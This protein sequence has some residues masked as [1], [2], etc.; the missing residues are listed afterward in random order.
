MVSQLKTRIRSAWGYRE[1]VWLRGIDKVWIYVQPEM[2][3]NGSVLGG[4][5]ESPH[6]KGL[7]VITYR[8]PTLKSEKQRRG[9][10]DIYAYEDNPTTITYDSLTWNI[11]DFEW[12]WYQ[13]RGFIEPL[14]ALYKKVEEKELFWKNYSF[15]MEFWFRWDTPMIYQLRQF[16]PYQ[17][18][19][20][21]IGEDWK[22]VIVR[23][24]T[25][26]TWEKVSFILLWDYSSSV[27]L[28][29]WSSVG[30]KYRRQELWKNIPLRQRELV[31]WTWYGRFDDDH[32][33]T[34]L[35]YETGWIAIGWSLPMGIMH[36]GEETTAR[37]S[38]V[39]YS[40]W[41]WIKLESIQREERTDDL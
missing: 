35:L 7:Y 28:S 21:K 6:R 16:S 18:A 11:Q 13:A 39:L 41:I 33:L 31:A 27:N 2:P 8:M 37:Y 15:H 14:L 22:N 34:K 3:P 10:Q 29:P 5:F 40:D 4:I 38:W 30:I 25:D 19:W 12:F 23:W 9:S 1:E 26:E 20:F 24:I 17:E 36:V 32:G